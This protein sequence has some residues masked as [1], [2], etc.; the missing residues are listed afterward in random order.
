[1]IPIVA[2][3]LAPELRAR[4]AAAA[5]PGAE[6][7]F[8]E[9]APRLLDL[10]AT[11]GALAVVTELVDA[12]GTDTRPTIALLAERVPGI[13]VIVL[14]DRPAPDPEA[15]IEL[16]RSGVSAWIHR[17]V[18]DLTP[19]LRAALARAEERSP[20]AEIVDQALPLVP[21]E[22][23]PFFVHCARAAVAPLEAGAA[24]RAAGFAPRTLRR[25]L[26]RAG[27]PPAWQIVRWNRVLHAAWRLHLAARPVKTV[28][29][30]LGFESAL[31][32]RKSFVRVTGE[33]IRSVLARG[34]FRYLLQRYLRA[35]GGGNVI[36]GDENG[37]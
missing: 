31:A 20:A 37:R 30:A 32:L 7:L 27:L 21:R 9:R 35:L 25:R 3:V 29:A 34:G 12:A 28:A 16:G 14:H 24:A 1:M 18:G 4:V 8:C 13:Q 15:L 17:A 5:G 36:S 10:A 6:L 2:L 26:R 22:L 23:R 11:R 33:T 19:A